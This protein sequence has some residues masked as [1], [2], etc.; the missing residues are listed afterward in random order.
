MNQLLFS[1]TCLCYVISYLARACSPSARLRVPPQA[2][3]AKA[4]Q[5]E[6]LALPFAPGKCFVCSWKIIKNDHSW[7]QTPEIDLQ[8]FSR[9]R[10]GT[11]IYNSERIVTSRIL[12]I[13]V[14]C[15][16]SRHVLYHTPATDN[17]SAIPGT[18]LSP[19]RSRTLPSPLGMT[20][21]IQCSMFG[22][23]DTS[24]LQ[25]FNGKNGLSLK[26]SGLPKACHKEALQKLCKTEREWDQNM[27]KSGRKDEADSLDL[28][29]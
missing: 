25:R 7:L 9:N 2:G 14:Q 5:S 18:S 15:V 12:G 13:L 27:S 1:C 3:G 4:T 22:T 19:K 21:S 24:N 10:S 6:R 16:A 28:I 26:F 29:I 17:I 20:W 8:M 11:K 23:T